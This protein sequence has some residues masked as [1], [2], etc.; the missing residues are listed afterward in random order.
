MEEKTVA[1]FKVDADLVMNGTAST[2][3]TLGCV[4][5]RIG[6]ASRKNQKDQKGLRVC[7][8]RSLINECDSEVSRTKVLSREE[9]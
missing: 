1:K 6:V 3:I 2:T 7:D 9:A 8:K 4:C 5:D